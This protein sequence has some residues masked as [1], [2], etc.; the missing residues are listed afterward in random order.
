MKI[1]CDSNHQPWTDIKSLIWRVTTITLW[2][3]Y[4]LDAACGLFWG[5]NEVIQ[6]RTEDIFLMRKDTA[7]EFYFLQL[8]HCTEEL[9]PA[10]TI[11]TSVW[12]ISLQSF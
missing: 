1:L 2:S 11:W 9:L 12:N 8:L 3:L 10:F 4:T 5:V 7:G 6:F